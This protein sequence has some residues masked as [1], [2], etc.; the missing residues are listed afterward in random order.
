VGNGNGFVTA[1]RKSTPQEIRDR[2]DGEVERFSNLET[3]QTATMDAPLVLDLVSKAAAATTPTARRLLD[4]GCGAG[5]YSLQL[6]TL[7]P[8]L[9]VDLVDLSP[10]MLERA[11]ERV[12]AVTS[13]EVRIMQGDIRELSLER[14]C[15][16]VIVA[17]AVL[18]HLRTEAEWEAVYGTLFAALRPGGALW[19]ADL[20]EHQIPGARELM[21][22]RYA[23][24]LTGIGGEEYQR[25][26]F[27]YIE[28]EDSPVPLSYQLDVMRRV[29]FG[30]IDVIHK[31]GCFAA[32]GGVKTT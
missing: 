30:R 12:G 31:N 29:G 5:N 22:Q 15:Y 1:T 10:R 7:L 14:D 16:D 8:D 26:V 18:H 20:V 9:D 11:A 2:F 13:G 19:V 28:Q 32:F 4:V 24:Y 6:L 3:G 25:K 23:D 21:W 27:A 17:A